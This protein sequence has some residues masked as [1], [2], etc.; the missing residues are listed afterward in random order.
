MLVQGVWARSKPFTLILQVVLPEGAYDITPALP[1]EA[2]VSFETKCVTPNFPK[3]L[4]SQICKTPE[5]H[6]GGHPI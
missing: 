6:L 1:V 4:E 2:D 5:T 3:A